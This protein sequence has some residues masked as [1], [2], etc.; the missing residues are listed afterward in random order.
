MWT[1]LQALRGEVAQLRQ[2]VPSDVD[3]KRVM[4]VFEVNATLRT[5][6]LDARFQEDLSLP[7]VKVNRPSPS[8]A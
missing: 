1:R 2:Q 7:L 6:A 8:S 5:L 4:G 3:K